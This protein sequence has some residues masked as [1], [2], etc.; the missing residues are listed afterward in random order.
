VHDLENP[1]QDFL[2][3]ENG[4]NILRETTL[5]SHLLE[6]CSH[7]LLDML[8][9]IGLFGISTSGNA[10]YLWLVSSLELLG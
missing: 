2:G 5:I 7:G 1:A 4:S 9:V 3:T 6:L 8:Y 10:V